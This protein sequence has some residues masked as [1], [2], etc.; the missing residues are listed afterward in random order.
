[1]QLVEVDAV[2]FEPAQAHFDTLD[3][4]AGAPHV[5]GLC[6]SLA[7]NTALGGDDHARRIRVQRLGNKALG[8]LRAISVGSVDQRDAQLHGPAEDATS[9][10]RIGWLAPRAFA[11]QAHGSVAE[12]VDGQV[13][14][15]EE[16]AACGCVLY[17]HVRL[18]ATAWQVGAHGICGLREPRAARLRIL[19][20][21]KENR[22]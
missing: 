10:G 14:A 8:N 20:Q 18:D 2:E 1:M 19:A 17:S 15:N 16:C 3:E 22:P 11:H 4:V 6:R 13:A 5:L 12:T 9:F 7:G 21:S